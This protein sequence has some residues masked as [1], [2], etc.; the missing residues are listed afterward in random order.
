MKIIEMI[1]SVIEKMAQWIWGGIDDVLQMLMP[2][3]ED[4]K[5]LSFC[6]LV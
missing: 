6:L 3:E 2:D 1:F 4:K 5:L